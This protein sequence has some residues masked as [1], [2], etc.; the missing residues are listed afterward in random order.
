MKLTEK[1]ERN[2]RAALRFLRYRIGSWEPIAR[3]LSK[4]TGTLVKIAGGRRTATP[5]LAY[6]VARLTRTS[7]DELLAGTG[8]RVCPHCGRPPD[9]FKDEETVIEEEAWATVLK[10]CGS[11]A[12]GEVADEPHDVALRVAPALR[13]SPRQVSR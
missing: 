12:R 11:D 8:L 5:E 1:E 9:D 4:A 6:S 3:A 10:L 2:V 7:L 13:R